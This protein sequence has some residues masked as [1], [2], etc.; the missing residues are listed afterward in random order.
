LLSRIAPLYDASEDMNTRRSNKNRSNNE[1][2][3]LLDART[4]GAQVFAVVW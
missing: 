4:I 3:L 2:Q 1:V